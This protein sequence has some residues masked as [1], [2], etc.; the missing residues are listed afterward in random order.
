MGNA[1]EI[2]RSDS[3]AGS[4]KD[5]PFALYFYCIYAHELPKL[6]QLFRKGNIIKIIK[7]AERATGYEEV[8]R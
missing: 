5:L 2:R 3:R 4:E 7:R 8:D 1:T 6:L